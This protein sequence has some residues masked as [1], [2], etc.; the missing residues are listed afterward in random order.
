MLGLVFLASL[1]LAQWGAHSKPTAAFYLLP[2]RGWELLIGAFAAFYL[3]NENH[4]DF[5]K[6]LSEFA[7]W[8]GFALI[9]L[10]RI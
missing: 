5:S 7:G 3:S 1:A 9:Q 2:T 8:L 6:G 4:K 10:L